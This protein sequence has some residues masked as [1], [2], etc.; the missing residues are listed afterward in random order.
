MRSWKC[1]YIVIA[2][3]LLLVAPAGALVPDTVEI[4]TSSEWLTAGSGETA[5]V[6]VLVT[7]GSTP[8]P[9]A[10]VSFASN[11]GSISPAVI[12]TDGAGRATAVFSPATTS[13]TV[14]I[15]AT[16][17]HEGLASPLTRSID[18]RIDHAAP[19]AVAGLWYEP[20]VTVGQTTTIAVRM[21][22]RY[23]NTVDNRKTAETVQFAVGSPSGS[24]TFVGGTDRVTASV[25]AAGNATVTLRVD[26]LPGENIV[27]VSLPEPLPGRYLTIS[28][29][30]NGEP[31]AIEVD[32][33]P[34]GDPPVATVDGVSR[35]VLT[36]TLLD[37]YGNPSSGRDVAI[38]TDASGDGKTVLTTN[39]Y[40]QVQVSYGPRLTTGG[41][42]VKATAVENASVTC[43][44]ALM[45][46]SND[47]VNLVLSTCPET[48]PSRDVPGSGPAVIRA[49]VVDRYGNPVAGETVS[50][51]IRNAFVGDFNQTAPPS[52]SAVSAVTNTYGIASVEFL[53]GEFT[54]EYQA[55]GYSPA[56]SGTCE[57]VATW[58]DIDRPVA[59]TWMNYPYLS[60]ETD[61]NPEAVT[62]NDTVDVTIRLKGDGW[63]MKPTPIDV[64]LCIDR[65]ETMISDYPD[66]MVT[67]MGAAPVLIEQLIPGWDRIG[68]LSF[69]YSG[70]AS[71]DLAK[72][73]KVC[74]ISNSRIPDIGV[75][76]DKSDDRDYIVH[77]PGTGNH[78]R[79]YPDHAVLDVPLPKDSS[80]AANNFGDV[81]ASISTLVPSGGNPVRKALYEGVTEMKEHGR[82]GAVRALVLL[83]DGDYDWYGDP[84]ARSGAYLDT[85]DP[86]QFGQR[87][88]NWY[89]FG[90]SGGEENMA[91]YAANNDVRIYTITFSSAVSTDCNETMRI[92]AETSGGKHYIARTSSDLIAVYDQ[93]A[94]DLKTEAGVNTFVDVTFENVEVDSAPVSGDEVFDYV[95][96][97]GVSTLIRSY[98]RTAVFTPAYTRDDTAAW[99]ANR[100]L[101]FDVGTIRLNQTWEAT[102]R[103][104]VLAEGTIG[105]FGDGAAIT[106]NDHDRVVLPRVYITAYAEENTTLDTRSLSVSDLNCLSPATEFLPLTWNLNYTGTSE[107]VQEVSCSGD[108]GY[109]WTRLAA[110]TSPPGAR[111][112]E[113]SLDVRD[114]LPGEY[115]VR[116]YATAADAPDAWQ[117]CR[118]ILIGDRQKDYIQLR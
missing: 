32:V 111:A 58:R 19:A 86:E 107:A 88:N 57:V 82:P 101:H 44:Q 85:K 105:L 49:K 114:F 13:G 89:P 92:I 4:S 35:F 72:N 16:V 31:C 87:T 109:T 37:G 67:V 50:F 5:T 93:I 1:A 110:L 69:G 41:V 118:Q 48:M 28:G 65:A 103:L 71:V 40:G 94:D 30:G 53:P 55:P 43:S 62:V 70:T 61:V 52:L 99:A 78:W 113:I 73:N 12:T 115:S 84:L 2:G 14:A 98:N 9:G 59:L 74:T 64:I 91:V 36:Y 29:A 100:R 38:T 6:T 10:A 54:T 66:H 42:V 81:R 21:A 7:N 90:L 39:A 34:G 96:E 11:M 33:R 15:T 102:F 20:V 46:V 97:E 51:S 108:G 68:L 76:Q 117:T 116:V 22:D 25:D 3:L 17:S 24:A 112:M 63:A 8:I 60:A 26:T 18:Q 47:P 80:P 83:V 104:K 45:F 27:Q 79:H 106:F 75:D 56:A 95:Y 77:Y 23:G